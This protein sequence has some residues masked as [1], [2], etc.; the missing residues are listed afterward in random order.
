MELLFGYKLNLLLVL[1][2]LV[3][4]CADLHSPQYLPLTEDA[5]REKVCPLHRRIHRDKVFY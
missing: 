3:K 5:T 1:H 4:D 2:G